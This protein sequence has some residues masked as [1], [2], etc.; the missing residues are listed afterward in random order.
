MSASESDT[1]TGAGTA[2]STG[3]GSGTGTWTGSGEICE[4]AHFLRSRRARLTP[5]A[6]GLPRTSTRRLN[7]LRRAEVATLAGISPEYYTRLEQGRQCR[8][9][10]AVLD[11]LAG[12]LRLDEDARRHLHRLATAAPGPRS[13][14]D[15]GPGLPELPEG[16]RRLLASLTPWPAHV[17]TP[18][19][20]VIAWNRAE[21]WLLP[22]LLELPAAHRNHAWFVFCDPRAH[23]LLPDWEQVARG[24]VHRLRHALAAD[25]RNPRGNRLVA[26]LIS[27]SRR[28][29]EI[30]EEHDVRGPAE[31]H[32]AFLHAEAGRLDLDYTAYVVPGTP[33][34][35]LVVLT[36]PE[37]S[38][39]HRALLRA[40]SGA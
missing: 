22:A 4:L 30:W 38:P 39:T 34:L 14:P 31:G 37:G 5:E 23:A 25:P 29:A 21:A 26:E 27:R 13:G 33:A 36:A 35:E 3:R 9:S 28:F 16:T 17:V 18:M 8:P 2:T 19:R 7:G 1:W 40:G 15:G 10:P 32:H 24:N 11:A 12:A 20:D 6:A